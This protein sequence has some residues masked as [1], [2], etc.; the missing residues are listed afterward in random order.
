[1]LFAK[2]VTKI[3]DFVIIFLNK[4]LDFLTYFESPP[5]FDKKSNNDP[6]NSIKHSKKR[7]Q[8]NSKQ[9]TSGSTDVLFSGF[10]VDFLTFAEKVQFERLLESVSTN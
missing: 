8:R 9:E 3:F 1:L 5:I 6:K 7:S 4:K 10:S 2:I